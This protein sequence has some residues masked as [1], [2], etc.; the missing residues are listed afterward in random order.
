MDTLGR[1]GIWEVGGLQ[2]GRSGPTKRAK[3]EEEEG[4]TRVEKVQ[5][6]PFHMARMENSNAASDIRPLNSQFWLTAE[7]IGRNPAMD[8]AIQVVAVLRAAGGRRW[9]RTAPL[10]CP[11]DHIRLD[12]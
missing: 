3:E 6:Y 9:R 7:K 1:L 4:K 8:R 12:S 11:K 10:F 2:K 5:S